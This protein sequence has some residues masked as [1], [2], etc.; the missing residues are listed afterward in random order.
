MVFLRLDKEGKLRISDQRR[1][2]CE[3]KNVGL[4]ASGD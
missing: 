1:V 3:E 4:E 2:N